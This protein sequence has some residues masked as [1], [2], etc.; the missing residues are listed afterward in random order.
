MPNDQQSAD[1]NILKRLVAKFAEATTCWFSSVRTDGRA[2]LAPIWHIWHAGNIY[3]CTPSGS[4][5]ARNIIQN[6]H[7]GLSLPD[8]SDVLIIEGIATPAPEIEAVLQPLFTE[9][10]DW[11]ISK[12]SDYDMIL[13]ISPTKI[14]AWG[15]HGEG[16]WCGATVDNIR[17]P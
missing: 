2:H 8:P 1:Q 14:I 17:L 16:R 11:D 5:R 7:V 3:V 6:S 13:G 12:D 9:K 4:V 15:T 10:Y